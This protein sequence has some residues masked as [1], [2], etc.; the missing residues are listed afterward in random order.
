MVIF[1]PPQKEIFYKETYNHTQ[2][3]IE[4]FDLLKNGS[5]L[6]KV[7]REFAELLL[8]TKVKKFHKMHVLYNTGN[9]LLYFLKRITTVALGKLRVVKTFFRFVERTFNRIDAFGRFFTEYN[10][11]VVFLPD[12]YG[13]E[14]ILLLKSARKRGVKVIGMVASWDNNTS[15]HLMRAIPDKLIVQNEIIKEEAERLHAVPSRIIKVVGIPHYDYYR[16]YQPVPR[17]EFCHSMGINPSK[18]IIVFSPAGEKFISTDWQICELLKRA[19]AGGKISDDVVILVRVHPTNITD[20]TQFVP[21]LHFVIDKP[22]VKFEG[23]G[24]KKNELD[25]KSIHHLLDTL[26]HSELVINIFSSIVIDAA[27]L[28]KPII[29][30]GFDGFDESA[31]F[32]RSVKRWISEDHM[33]KLLRTGGAPIVKTLDELIGQINKYLKNPALDRQGRKRIVEEQCWKTDGLSKSRMAK[34]ILNE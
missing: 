16:E 12:I 23:M 10:P 27:V 30:I 4:V 7:L 20:L 6:N 1:V 26:H 9:Y 11:D 33:D 14:D 32:I 5:R 2:V 8:N 24:E 21:D 19:Y 3:K 34:V 29:T 17:E 15:K 13:E 25:K 22:G 18:R 31:P 28:D